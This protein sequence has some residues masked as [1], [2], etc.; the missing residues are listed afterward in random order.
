MYHAKLYYILMVDD[1][2]FERLV[3]MSNYLFKFTII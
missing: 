1:K 2:W 3:K